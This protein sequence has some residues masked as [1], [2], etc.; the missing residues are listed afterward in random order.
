MVQIFLFNEIDQCFLWTI[1]RTKFKQN[2]GRSAIKSI[3]KYT[4]GSHSF[5]NKFS[6]WIKYQTIVLK[7]SYITSSWFK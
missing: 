4:I 6:I 1:L 2:E 5:F 3:E 7:K